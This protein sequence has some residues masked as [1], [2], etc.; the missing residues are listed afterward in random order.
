VAVEAAPS[1]AAAAE[2][3]GRLQ[4][5]LLDQPG[6]GVA[7]DAAL[8]ELTPAGVRMARSSGTAARLPRLFPGPFDSR[9][10]DSTF[11]RVFLP[12]TGDYAANL[13][14]EC[15]PNSF[16]VRSGCRDAHVIRNVITTDFAQNSK[17]NSGTVLLT[18]H[19]TGSVQGHG[20]G[21]AV[22]F[23]GGIS[24]HEPLDRVLQRLVSSTGRQQII[25]S[26]P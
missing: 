23:A 15:K 18:H 25:W 21:I 6:N 2:V 4:L 26:Q 22:G 1:P 14:G 3:V 8:V 7:L 9:F 11:L 5:N 20:V 16:L 19:S 17:G 24:L 13:D 10:V 12:L